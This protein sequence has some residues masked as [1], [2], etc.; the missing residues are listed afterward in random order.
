MSVLI[1][2]GN[3]DPENLEVAASYR[4]VREAVFAFQPQ[5]QELPDGEEEE[6]D[7]DDDDSSEDELP[8][9]FPAGPEE[10]VPGGRVTKHILKGSLGY[11]IDITDHGD[12]VGFAEMA[13]NPAQAAGVPIPSKIVSVNGVPV[14]TKRD[15]MSALRTVTAGV[16]A[17]F[18]FEVPEKQDSPVKAAAPA[19]ATGEGTSK[20]S[21][22]RREGEACLVSALTNFKAAVAQGGSDELAPIVQ[23]RWLL[24]FVSCCLSMSVLG[25]ATLVDDGYILALTTKGPSSAS[26][27]DAACGC[28]CSKWRRC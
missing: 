12:A 11:G 25:R 1:D 27:F 23:V 14:H 2:A 28:W 16:A 3:C 5:Q 20:A 13:S 7:D 6:D 18:I 17:E 21:L 26:L 10:V 9:G 15:I 19:A 4:R 22:L 24:V 8:E